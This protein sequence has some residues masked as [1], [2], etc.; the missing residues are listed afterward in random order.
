M[1]RNYS[2]YRYLLMNHR[3]QS[4]SAL[5]IAIFVLVVVLGFG[6]TLANIVVS[7]SEAVAYEILGTRA[8]LAANSG[9]QQR[10]NQI[11]T[12]GQAN[13]LCDGNP[14]PATPDFAE[15]PVD[16]RVNT[17]NSAA[18]LECRVQRVAC[19]NFKQDGVVFYR[20]E[21]TGQC[22]ASGGE[23]ITRTVVVEA[24]N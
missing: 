22:D 17:I 12:P 10:L 19:T 3:K 1:S 18:L 21:S 13:L 7:S 2:D 8:F 9:A 16:E 6:L 5:I 4:G 11:F 24:R 15:Q 23:V 20:I 14:N